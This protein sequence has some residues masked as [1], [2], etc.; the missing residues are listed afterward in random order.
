MLIAPAETTS[1]KKR[2]GKHPLTTTTFEVLQT[3]KTWCHKK[4]FELMGSFWD[5][6]FVRLAFQ[7][8]SQN[9]VKIRNLREVLTTLLSVAG[10]LTLHVIILKHDPSIT[11]YRASLL[12]RTYMRGQASLCRA[13]APPLTP[14]PTP[15]PSHQCFSEHVALQYLAWWQ[16]AHAS[17]ASSAPQQTQLR[18]SFMRAMASTW[19][20]LE[21]RL[22]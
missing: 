11:S 8:V 9:V 4:I 18:S 1:L 12:L 5:H 15:P 2:I 13:P 3:L 20:C 7:K 21:A 17:W 10:F 6:Y 14:P 16:S 22:M 19:P